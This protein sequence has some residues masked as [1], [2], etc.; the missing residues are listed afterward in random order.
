MRHCIFF[1]LLPFVQIVVRASLVVGVVRGKSPWGVLWSRAW[2][3][4]LLEVMGEG[5][6]WR[7]GVVGGTIHCV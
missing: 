5:N 1:D 2:V 4:T 6:D 3:K 7:C